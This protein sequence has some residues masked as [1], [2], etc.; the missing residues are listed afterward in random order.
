MAM[1]FRIE[2]LV[3]GDS[4]VL[5]LS[6]R[7]H[8]EH[9]GMLRGL[10]RLEE[11]R[12]VVDLREV[13]LLDR[14]AV[15]FLALSEAQGVELR[16]CAAYIREWVDRERPCNDYERADPKVGGGDDLSDL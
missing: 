14:E 5:R 3:S 15:S 8:A 4:V 2:R 13:T 9:L 7:M 12:V 6:G 10:L 1:G 11:A 16:N